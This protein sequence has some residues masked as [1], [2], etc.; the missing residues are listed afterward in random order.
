MDRGDADDSGLY[1]VLCREVLDTISSGVAVYQVTNDGRRGRDYII[2]DF[3]R[4]ALELEG[5]R[6]AEVVGKSLFDLRPNIDDFGLIPIFREVWQSGAPGFYPATVY[7]DAGF[8]NW[9][10]NRIFRLSNDRIVAVYD[11]VTERKQSEQALAGSEA[12]LREVINGMDHAIAIY[13]A[14]DDGEDFVFVTMNKFAEGITHYRIDEVI[15]ERVSV[16]FPG[17]PSVGLISKLAEAWRTGATLTIPL[18]QYEDERITQWVENTI[19]KLPSGKVVAVFQDTSEQ[20]MAEQAQRASE[21]ELRGYIENAPDSIVFVD[22]SGRC[23]D[24]NSATIELTG[25]SRAEL[26]ARSI[27]DMVPADA[28]A[29]ARAHFDQAQNEGLAAG[30]ISILRKDGERRTWNVKAVRLT[31]GRLMAF[32]TDISEQLRQ[33]DKVRELEE[34]AHQSQKLETVGR[35]AGG[36]AH[37]FNN[38]LTVINSYATFVAEDLDEGD[39]MRADVEQIREAGDRA[40]ALTRQL[41][42]FSR[43]QILAPRILDLNQVVGDLTQMMSRLLGEDIDFV[44]RLAADLGQVRA[45]PSQVEQVLM[46]LAVNARDAMADGGKLTVETANIDLDEAYLSAH[47]DATQGSHVLLAVSDTGP[48]MSDEIKSRIFEPFFT[49]KGRGD[50]TGLGLATVYGIVK[51]SGGAIRVHS[52]LG[53]GATFKVY[54]PRVVGERS[55]VVEVSDAGDLGGTET[56]LVVEDEPAVRLLARR[57]LESSGY[58]V[59]AAA[60]GGEALLLCEQRVGAI[61]LVLTD[62]V[63]PQMSGRALVDRLSEICPGLTVLFM[64]GY[65][66]NAIVHHGVLDEGTHFIAKPFTARALLEKVRLVLDGAD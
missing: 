19:F 7:V 4:A 33:R 5:K 24:V 45:D 27:G 32:A 43:K 2:V 12:L 34:Q 62:V 20:R 51:Q 8:A 3:N 37:D 56:I 23:I 38:L 48:G 35:L 65:T 61:G 29:L 59:L 47:P 9:Y 54:L 64:S 14:V 26:L 21:E 39:P 36:I 49:T 42:A 22:E 30:E 41:L 15:G 58:R 63:M 6:K 18:R 55:E 31:E 66:D 17:E 57:I 44:T 1:E 53:H 10:E 40:A 25:Y 60:N 11:D 46:N 52:E 50:G 13:E 16:L 28:R